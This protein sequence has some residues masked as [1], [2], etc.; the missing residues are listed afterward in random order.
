MNNL[1]FLLADP[2]VLFS[3]GGLVTLLAICTF[4]VFFFLKKMNNNE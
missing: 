4:Y 2:I 1:S 3:A